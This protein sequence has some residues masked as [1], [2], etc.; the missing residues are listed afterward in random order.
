MYIY[1]YIY[2]S[3][4]ITISIIIYQ[5]SIIYHYDIYHHLS[6]PTVALLHLDSVFVRKSAFSATVASPT[7]PRVNVMRNPTSDDTYPMKKK[8]C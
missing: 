2:I 3:C 6:R 7:L 5:S 8:S 4:I 1:L